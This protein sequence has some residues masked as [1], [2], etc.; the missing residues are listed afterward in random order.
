M[1]VFVALLLV[2]LTV[3]QWRLWF[4][5]GSLQELSRLRDQSAQSRSEVLRLTIR[6]HALAAE[7]ADLKSGLDAIEERARGELGMI[8][9]DETFYRFIHEKSANKNPPTPEKKS[10]GGGRAQKR[11]DQLSTAV[12]AVGEG[13]S[14]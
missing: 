3:L 5:N 12:N 14:Q 1:K 13:E 10:S 2:L 11:I 9:E 4:G 6:N 7:V 8:N